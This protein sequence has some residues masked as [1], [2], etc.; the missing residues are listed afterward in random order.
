[1]QKTAELANIE[2]FAIYS[3]KKSAKEF[4]CMLSL[5]DGLIHSEH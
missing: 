4:G 2:N 1:M 3:D 5:Q